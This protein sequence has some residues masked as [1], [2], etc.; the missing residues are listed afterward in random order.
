M[1]H[2]VAADGP[3][4]F[5]ANAV[6]LGLSLPSKGGG[7]R[8]AEQTHVHCNHKA[9]SGDGGFPAT[10]KKIKIQ[11]QGHGVAVKPR[12]SFL[13]WVVFLTWLFFSSGCLPLPIGA[14]AL[15]LGESQ[16]NPWS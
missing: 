7:E 8:A 9:M 6:A 16:T 10:T 13:I 1:H 4:G 15:G 14:K 12:F 3:L 5:P 11:V 2:T